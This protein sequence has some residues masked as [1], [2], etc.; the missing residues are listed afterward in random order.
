ML[1]LSHRGI[2]APAPEN[3]LEAFDH[4]ARAGADGVETDVRLSADG[5][6]VLV[7][8]RVLPDGRPVADAPRSEIERGLG[9]VV[10]TAAE[11][12]EAFPA[13]L[14]NLEIKTREVVPALLALL[15]ARS[16]RT[17]ILLTSFHHDVIE[18]IGP[19]PGVLRG[20]LVAHRPFRAAGEPLGWWPRSQAPDAIVWDYETLDDA[21]VRTAVARG[22]QNFAYGPRTRD[23]HERCRSLALT[24]VITDDVGQAHP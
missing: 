24:G 8:D 7:H 17:R 12:L 4:V 23:E 6:L 18:R 11:A 16:P 20:V 22:I 1:V 5:A 15:V 21:A 3:T 10:P 14:W 13:L 2:G 9:H 19:L